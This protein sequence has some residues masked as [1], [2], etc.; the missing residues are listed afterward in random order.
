MVKLAAEDADQPRHRRRHGRLPPRDRLLPP[1]GRAVGGPVARPTWRCTTR[2]R[3]GSRW[4]SRTFGRRAGR[5]DRRL[6]AGGG[7]RG[8]GRAGAG[9]RA[10]AGRPRPGHSDWLNQPSP[11]N[12]DLLTALLPAF[13][14]RYQD[15]V[16]PEHRKVCER[17]VPASTPG[18]RI[19]ARPSGWSTAT[20]GST[21]CSSTTGSAPSVD[22]QTFRGARPCT[23][24]LLPRRRPVGRGS[25]RARA[26]AG[27]RLPRRAAAQGVQ[28]FAWE[29]CWDGYRRQCFTGIVMTIAASMLVER[30]GAA[31]KCSG[32]LER[33]PRWRSTSTP[34]RCCPKRTPRAPSPFARARGRGTHAPGPEELWNE[35]WYFDGVSTTA[36]SAS[37]PHRPRCRTSTA[38]CS[39]R[40]SAARAGRRSCSSTSGAASA[41]GRSAPGDP[42][43][44]PA[45]GSTA[46][47]RSSGFA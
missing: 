38:A 19:A 27:S 3:A 11:L 44:R 13:L 41:G 39:A 22:W 43:P 31:T 30:T 47:S 21:T 28:S 8:A 40:A 45:P 15:R 5:P 37:T 1:S 16:A 33:T 24:V 18:P 29:H 6:F 42:R 25:P 46:R 9:P 4:S 26:G 10:G 36:S 32:P 35:S 17:L 34:S 12:Q 2:A 20:T 14:E 7:A 23:T